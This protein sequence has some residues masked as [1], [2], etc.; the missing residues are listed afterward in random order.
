MAHPKF[1]D[2]NDLNPCGCR[3]SEL[4]ADHNSLA[5]IAK[6]QSPSGDVAQ[7]DNAEKLELPTGKPFEP[8]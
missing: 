5:C 1:H 3:S 6:K 4:E 2:E 7:S 8:R